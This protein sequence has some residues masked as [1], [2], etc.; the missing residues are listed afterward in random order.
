LQKKQNSCCKA[1]IWFISSVRVPG[2]ALLLKDV[3][4]L[5]WNPASH[6]EWRI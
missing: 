2:P 5:T 6:S 4:S 1:W 3:G